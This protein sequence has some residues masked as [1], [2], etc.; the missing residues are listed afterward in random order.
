MQ[1]ELILPMPPST[2]RI[3][4]P[5]R[6]A[7]GARMVKRGAYADWKHNAAREV[8]A[9]R[10]GRRIDCKFRAHIV[11]PRTGKDSDNSTKPL[12]DACQAGGAIK[13]DALCEGGS[14]DFDDTREGTALVVLV[15]IDG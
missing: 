15:P 12:L 14:W 1:L 2:N 7:T 5:V 11:L 9:Q 13:N 6:T 10:K 8:M 4:V 3:W